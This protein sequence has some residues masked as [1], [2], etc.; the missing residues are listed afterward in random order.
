MQVRPILRVLPL[1]LALALPLV[2]CKS[3]EVHDEGSAAAARIDTLGAIAGKAQQRLDNALNALEKVRDEAKTNPTPAFQSFS[4]ELA[5]YTAELNNLTTGRNSMKSTVEGWLRNYEKQNSTIEDESLREK[6]NERLEGF[7]TRVSEV[8]TQIDGLMTD[9]T[10]T[11]KVLK[12]VRAYLAGD[13]TPQ[14]IDSVSGRIGDV[15][16][17]GRKVASRLGAFREAAMSAASNLRAA[18]AAAPPPAKP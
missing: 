2:S 8:G 5:Q 15:A 3:T 10:A 4:D 12:D 9:A 17:D 14:G 6:A 18:Q 1:A 11:Q 16:S 13:L 7:R